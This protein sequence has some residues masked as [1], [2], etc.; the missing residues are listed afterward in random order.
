[1][2]PRSLT[3]VA[4]RRIAWPTLA[5]CTLAVA[6]LAQGPTPVHVDTVR[7][8]PVQDHRPVT[9]DVRAVRRAEVASREP[10][11]LLEL[12]VREG[13]RVEAGA[14]LAR[15][16]A[17]RL[18]LGHAVLTAQR[19]PAQARV[20]EQESEREQ[21]ARDVETLDQLAGREAA[22]PKELADART[23]LSSAEARLEEARGELLVIEARLAELAKRIEDTRVR[24][25]F[26][27]TVTA[28][29]TE[30]GAWLREGDPVVEIVST[31][32]LELWL[33][34]PQQLFGAVRR[35]EG[36]SLGALRVR[37][38]DEELVLASYR[39]I[40]DVD[41]RAR[42]F[43]LVAARDGTA[44]SIRA[45]GMSVTAEIPTGERTERL[46]LPRDAVQRNEVGPNV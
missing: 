28:R 26:A 32:D 2:T 12:S 25:P 43:H 38:G 30:I 40:P 20:R 19:A 18:E 45:A 33:E 11:F 7:S 13:E 1:M 15:V 6:A 36:E 14:L 5:A 10:G 8:E 42:T 37:I 27:G 22:N 21:S 17:E 44:R 23:A 4:I 31:D 9:G 41:V 46:T 3:S 16:D 39:A 34:V 35:A 29:R 24:A